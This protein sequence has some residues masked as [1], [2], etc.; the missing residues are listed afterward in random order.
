MLTVCLVPSMRYINISC[1]GDGDDGDG[2]KK[3]LAFHSLFLGP[4]VLS[5]LSI[6]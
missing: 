6:S 1:D 5:S 4:L 3:I 2:L